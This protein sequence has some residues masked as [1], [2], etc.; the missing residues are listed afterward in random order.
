MDLPLRKAG[1]DRPGKR[2]PGQAASLRPHG[3]PA[4]FAG[5]ELPVTLVV[6]LLQGQPFPFR[7]QLAVV[8][9]PRVAD[10]VIGGRHTADVGWRRGVDPVVLGLVCGVRRHVAAEDLPE[11]GLPFARV[12]FG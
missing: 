3:D 7:F 10:L 12:L 8:V 1:L 4:G 5:P 6:E 11:E 2:H 9:A